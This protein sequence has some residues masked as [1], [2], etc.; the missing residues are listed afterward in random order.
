MPII[1]PEKL[2]EMQRQ[3]AELRSQ[4]ELARTIGTREGFFQRYFKLLPTSRTQVEA[5]NQVNEEYLE[6]FG[7]TKYQ[8]YNSFR[9]CCSRYLKS[10]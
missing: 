5:F 1:T 3:S 9:N 6:I 10:K 8:E 4:Y 7:E 2:A